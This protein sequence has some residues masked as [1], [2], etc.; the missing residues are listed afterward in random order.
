MA[1]KWLR[2]SNGWLDGELMVDGPMDDE[3]SLF[4]M[5]NN[6]HSSLILTVMGYQVR[7]HI[8]MQIMN[9]HG[10]WLTVLKH[11]GNLHEKTPSIVNDIHGCSD[12]RTLHATEGT[13]CPSPTPCDNMQ[14]RNP[15][16][17]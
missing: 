1:S 16:N 3:S 15:V 7:V 17:V 2:W 4:R 11:V 14:A 8:Q 6:S 5:V 10:K 9:A 12:V 13:K